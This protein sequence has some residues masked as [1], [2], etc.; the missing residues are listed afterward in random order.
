MMGVTRIFPPS[1]FFKVF[2]EF[3]C[4]LRPDIVNIDLPVLPVPVHFRRAVIS[5]EPSF[6]QLF[7][8][9]FV[10]N[11]FLETSDVY[12]VGISLKRFC[13]RACSRTYLNLL[14]Y[15]IDLIQLNIVRDKADLGPVLFHVL[16]EQDLL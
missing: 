4:Y 6:N 11:V 8:D 15:F 12:G 7:I 16:G 14:G 3:Y 13:Y 2:A 5:W 1:S 9:F 10:S